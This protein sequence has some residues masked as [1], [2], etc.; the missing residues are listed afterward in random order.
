MY[1]KFIKRHSI[2]IK[3]GVVAKVNPTFGER[4]LN[5]GYAEKSTEEEFESFKSKHYGV[6]TKEEKP[7]KKGK[8]KV[9]S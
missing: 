3:E 4:M 2:G 9:K 6:E 5:D 8:K 7:K 1:I